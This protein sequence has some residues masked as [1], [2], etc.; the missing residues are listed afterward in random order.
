MPRHMFEPIP[1]NPNLRVN[2]QLDKQ[3]EKFSNIR[4]V[5]NELNKTFLKFSFNGESKSIDESMIP[6]YGSHGS[7]QQ[8][9]NKTIRV[10]YSIWFLAETYHSLVQFEPHQGVKKEKQT[11]F[12]LGD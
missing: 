2:E 4:L 3:L 10:G 6:Y 7:G 9:N 11:V 5:I 1:R 8:I 12:L